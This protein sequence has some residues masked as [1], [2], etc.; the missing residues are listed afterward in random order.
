MSRVR[1]F[2]GIAFALLL[3]GC[4]GSGSDR[5]RFADEGDRCGD[6]RV[7]YLDETGDELFCEGYEYKGPLTPDEKRETIR[8][9]TRLADDGD[10]SGEDK[11]RVREFADD[12]PAV[13]RTHLVPRTIAAEGESVLVLGQA[14]D[15]SYHLAE[16]DGVS[17]TAKT[18]QL[19]P[20]RIGN[21]AVVRDQAWFFDSTVI[22][23]ERVPVWQ[24]DLDAPRSPQ[25]LTVYRGSSASIEAI[26]ADGESL[27]AALSI[28]EEEGGERT[29][30]V[31][32]IDLREQRIAASVELPGE[33]SIRSL[34][35]R[36]GVV[37]VEGEGLPWAIDASA[38]RA[39]KPDLGVLTSPIRLGGGA[40]WALGVASETA[41]SPRLFRL[42]P[43]TY[44]LQASI[45]VASDIVELEA[46][47]SA[48]WL[49][50]EN[51]RLERVGAK[52]KSLEQI[53]T[54][55]V[56]TIAPLDTPDGAAGRSLAA[57]E[58]AAWVILDS[59][60]RVARVDAK[61]GEVKILELSVDYSLAADT[62]AGE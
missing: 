15:S 7:L 13:A 59:S 54:L 53:A 55:D 45:P 56:E 52:G 22:Y 51:G 60:G 18:S 31:N 27:W 26:A 6:T 61:T 36:N 14:E 37:W 21:F 41:T 30:L 29:V 19:F 32:R 2:V 1:R 20:E 12:P 9:A 16:I 23:S 33:G 42:D 17:E 38:N 48:L 4:G 39:E 24:I 40:I 5:I 34:A 25:E 11:D 28:L 8:L 57:T 47:G 50:H 3:A 58:E 62:V 44:A 43:E 46:T 49:L 10:L 35:I